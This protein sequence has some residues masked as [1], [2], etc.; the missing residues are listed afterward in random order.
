MQANAF[1][2]TAS[3]LIA[4]GCNSNVD[5]G[6]ALESQAA[7]RHS[8]TSGSYAAD[9]RPSPPTRPSR[10]LTDSPESTPRTSSAL[11]VLSIDDD[12]VEEVI[13][14]ELFGHHIAVFNMQYTGVNS[15]IGTFEY[16]GDEFGLESGIIMSTGTATSAMGENNTSQATTQHYSSGDADLN[17]MNDLVSFDAAAIEFDFMTS[18]D[19]LF[20]LEFILASEEYPEFTGSMFSDGFAVFISETETDM[21]PDIDEEPQNIALM[22]NIDNVDCDLTEDAIG[23]STITPFLNPCL[24]IDND[25]YTNNDELVDVYDNL[26]GDD[27]QYDGFTRPLRLKIPVERY[28]NYR[29][30]IVIADAMD[31][32]FDTAVFIKSGSFQGAKHVPREPLVDAP[33]ASKL[34]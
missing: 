15:A 3:I 28:A 31:A 30:K 9:R 2:L 27:T 26:E 1:A 14:D 16:E 21:D 24:Y 29:I 18:S 17:A 32:K 34:K 33:Y 5:Y 6:E 11:E 8:N 20:A 19:E 4:T 23:I 25:L 13:A 10:D 7:T 22:E 12:I